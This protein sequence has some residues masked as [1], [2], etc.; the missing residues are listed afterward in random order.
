MSDFVV[1]LASEQFH[2]EYAELIPNI[3]SLV[4]HGFDSGYF[5]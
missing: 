3:F 4:D 5:L 1:W 2:G